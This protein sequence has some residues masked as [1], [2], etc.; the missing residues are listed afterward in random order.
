MIRKATLLDLKELAS[1]W[2]ALTGE[3]R[4]KELAAARDT[5]PRVT[6]NDTDAWAAD[7]AA[8]I[9]HPDVCFLVSETSG[10][11]DGYMVSSVH[12]RPVG[13]PDRVLFVSA[14][15]VNEEARKH[16]GGTLAAELIAATTEWARARKLTVAECDCVPANRAL[17]ETRGFT[18][19]AHRLWKEI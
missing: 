8:H 12:I 18:L 5:Y 13:Q 6:L 10:H 19:A 11:L 17:W 15:Y 4:A 3:E 16:N 7:A 9:L 14:L 2:T 1:L